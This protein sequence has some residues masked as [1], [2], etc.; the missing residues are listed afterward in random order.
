[1]ATYDGEVKVLPLEH[2]L[3]INVD[4]VRSE[5]DFIYAHGTDAKGDWETLTIDISAASS[6]ESG[7]GMLNFGFLVLGTIALVTMLWTAW[8]RS[9][10]F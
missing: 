7:R 9:K 6:I 4:L 10:N 5:G 3:P 1:M 8:E 2:D